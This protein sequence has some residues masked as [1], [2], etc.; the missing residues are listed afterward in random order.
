MMWKQLVLLALV[1][2]L[3]AN[4]ELGLQNYVLRPKDFLRL[5]FHRS[6]LRRPRIQTKDVTGKR[7]HKWL[8][9]AIPLH[10]EK[11]LDEERKKILLRKIFALGNQR[12]GSTETLSFKINEKKFS[13]L[14]SEIKEERSQNIKDTNT[15]DE[16]NF[17]RD[18]YPSFQMGLKWY[19][20]IN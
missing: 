4:N 16:G 11:K 14:I 7:S 5:S 6:F 1:T 12:N 9:S 20:R 18:L 10:E 3:L 13:S 2:S 19:N 8:D 17:E 15:I